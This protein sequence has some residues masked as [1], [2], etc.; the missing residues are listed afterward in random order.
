MRIVFIGCVSFSLRALNH[1]SE[2]G[3]NISGVCTLQN[4]KFNADHAD[5]SEFCNAHEIP[6]METP[7][8]NAQEVLDQIREWN[9]DIIFCFG[10]SRLLKRD[11]LA[12]PPKGVL[13]FH[14]AAL[15]ENRGRHPIIWALVLGLTETAS[16]FFF[17]DER[18]D[19]GDIL[20]QRKVTIT[21]DDNATSLYDRICKIAL[22]Q[23]S[24]FFPLL[25]SGSYKRIQQDEAKANV[26]RKRGRADGLID[27]R[28]SA[29]SIHNL[30]RG[31]THPYVGASFEFKGTEYKVWKTTAISGAQSNDEPGKIIAFSGISP[32]VR[33]GHDRIIL[34]EIEPHISLEVGEYL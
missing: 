20:S 3:G 5:L 31:L 7:D 6:W 10:W 4:S 14:P 34:N 25:I 17:M 28:M 24:D 15:P 23:I 16:T 19:G 1:I 33:C 27:W 26:W 8:I 13:G 11:L 29:Y 32:I 22:V 12:I 9:P 2:I 18:A 21:P 30:V